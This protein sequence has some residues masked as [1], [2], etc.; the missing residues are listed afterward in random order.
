MHVSQVA[1][2]KVGICTQAHTKKRGRVGF[3]KCLKQSTNLPNK[4]YQQGK[5]ELEKERKKKVGPSLITQQT[6]F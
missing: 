6:F 1:D 2:P 5:K 4:V 3:C